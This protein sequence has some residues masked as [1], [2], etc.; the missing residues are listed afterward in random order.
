M[1][2]NNHLGINDQ[3]M[4]KSPSGS[5]KIDSFCSFTKNRLCKII[6]CIL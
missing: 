6:L 1:S 5:R 3:N 4:E 2:L